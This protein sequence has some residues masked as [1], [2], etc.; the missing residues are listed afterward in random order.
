MGPDA[1]DALFQALASAT[2][3][4]ILDVVRAR[5]GC[6][7]SHVAAHFAV[8][9]ITVLKHLRVL[10]SA[11]LIVS[12]KVGRTRRLYFNC[13]PIQ[14]IYDRWTTDYSALWAGKLTEIKYRVETQGKKGDG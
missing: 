5:P 8:S 6:G 4:T 11:G 1:T 9:R 10:E 3:R 2:R 12:D 14:I 7:V 13:V